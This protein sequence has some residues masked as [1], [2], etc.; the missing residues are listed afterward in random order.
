[1]GLNSSQKSRSET[2]SQHSTVRLN[3]CIKHVRTRLNAILTLSFKG[4]QK[5][6]A[7]SPEQHHNVGK[8]RAFGYV[9]LVSSHRRKMLHP[10][11]VKLHLFDEVHWKITPV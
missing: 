6:G 3:E 2:S 7:L 8:K 4:T 1:M 9:Q 5:T 11:W 10:D